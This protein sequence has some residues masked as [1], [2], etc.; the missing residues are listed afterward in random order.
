MVVGLAARLVDEI[1][2]TSL[3]D[4]FV[5]HCFKICLHDVHV[6]SSVR[7]WFQEHFFRFLAFAKDLLLLLA[8]RCI[9][10]EP[11]IIQRDIGIQRS[12]E[13]VSDVVFDLVT[14]P[15]GDRKSTR[16]NST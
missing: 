15:S 7:L 14:I 9:K 1:D 3:A 2:G 8:F 11:A 13:T 16:L 5:S 6:I 10:A 4:A 12:R